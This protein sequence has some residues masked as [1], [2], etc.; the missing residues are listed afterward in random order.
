VVLIFSVVSNQ[1]Q[2]KF[3]IDKGGSFL[4]IALGV[5]SLYY[6]KENALSGD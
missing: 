2:R 5:N 4:L 3:L 6:G 1:A